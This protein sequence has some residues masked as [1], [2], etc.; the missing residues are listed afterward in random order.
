MAMEIARWW[1]NEM[2]RYSGR[3]MTMMMPNAVRF[4][5]DD[6]RS[7]SAVSGPSHRYK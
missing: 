5:V 6:L 4:V 2:E 1:T 3:D 7:L